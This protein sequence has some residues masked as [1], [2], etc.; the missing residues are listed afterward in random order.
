MCI[1]N[2][3][4]PRIA[5]FRAKKSHNQGLIWLNFK[6]FRGLRPLDPIHISLHADALA[7]CVSRTLSPSKMP[8][9][10]KSLPP[11]CPLPHF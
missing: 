2:C 11:S 3:L 10:I 6:S 5:I 7:V 8:P 9:L 1:D 4:K